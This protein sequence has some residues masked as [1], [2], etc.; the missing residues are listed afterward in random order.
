[1]G[2][3]S[4]IE[5]THHTF[6]PWW[7]CVKVAPECAHCYAETFAKRTGHG[8]WGADSPR[9]FFGEKHWMEPHKWNADAKAAGERRRVFCASMADVFEDGEEQLNRWRAKLFLLIYETPNLDWLLLTK[10]PENISVMM[11]WEYR[12]NP[13]ENIWLGT[14]A[15]TQAT[16]DKNVAALMKIPAYVRFV[17]MEPLLEAVNPTISTKLADLPGEK[18]D[19]IIVGG[20]SGPNAR[21]THPDWVRT[22]RDQCAVADVPFFFK[23]W[24][25]YLHTEEMDT[26]TF[27]GTLDKKRISVDDDESFVRV[28]KKQAGRLLDGREWSEFPA[29]AK[30]KYELPKEG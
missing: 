26:N 9:R 16:W 1:M 25:E 15:G 20:E 27:Y 13:P 3:D 23:Q 29:V 12:A 14:S 10:R 6:N 24:G 5:W 7:G 8:V 21:P 22:I 11:S 30:G 2:K 28:G 18:P 4:K 17:S 19:W